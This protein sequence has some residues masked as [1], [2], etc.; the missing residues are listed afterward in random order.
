[1][2]KIDEKA[3]LAAYQAIKQTLLRDECD[4]EDALAAA[5]LAYKAAEPKER[6]EVVA[7][8]GGGYGL[9]HYSSCPY[10]SSGGNNICN[11]KS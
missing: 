2:T 11:C 10:P 1:M 7:R 8:S 4:F 6:L 5:I 3:Y 9:M